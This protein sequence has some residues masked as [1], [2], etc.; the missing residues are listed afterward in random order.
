MATK[1]ATVRWASREIAEEVASANAGRIARR[2]GGIVAND[3]RVRDAIQAVI[4]KG[5]TSG[6]AVLASVA[7]ALTT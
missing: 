7:G 2:L 1:T 5:E 6:D 3:D 4:N